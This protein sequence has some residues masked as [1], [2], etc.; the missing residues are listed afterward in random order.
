MQL[1]RQQN[2]GSEQLWMIGDRSDGGFAEAY[3]YDIG[4]AKSGGKALATSNKARLSLEEI[5]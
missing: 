1:A 5:S 4:S 2:S 3:L